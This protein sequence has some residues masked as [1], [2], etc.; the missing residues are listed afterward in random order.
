[1][2]AVPSLETDISLLV[3]LL[4]QPA[5]G[6]PLTLT[7][8]PQLVSQAALRFA[9][10]VPRVRGCAELSFLLRGARAVSALCQRALAESQERLITVIERRG[11]VKFHTRRVDHLAKRIARP[12]RLV[13]GPAAITAALVGSMAFTASPASAAGDF[14]VIRNVQTNL[15]VQAQTNGE[16][17]LVQTICNTDSPAQRWVFVPNSNGNHILN[18]L[19]GLCVYMNGPVAPDSPVIQTGCFTVTNEDWKA[20][21]PPAITTI[22]SRASH[23]DTNLCL[24]PESSAVG[25]LLRIFNC[26]NSNAQRWV[27]GV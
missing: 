24:A 20:S 1:L 16:S 21:M 22:M 26:D 19:S 7:G 8:R 11:I 9:V 25:A 2:I 17:S 18:Q 10:V 27:I 14:S 4:Y 3:F 23:R 6:H 12:L 13:V 5:R 15:C